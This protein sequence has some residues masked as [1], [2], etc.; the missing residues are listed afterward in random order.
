M[1]QKYKLAALTTA[2][3]LF[4]G[5]CNATGQEESSRESVPVSSGSAE[6]S[7]A[8]DSPAS[9][10]IPASSKEN[11]SSQ[12]AEKPA[13]EDSEPKE[14]F[15][16]APAGYEPFQEESSGLYQI[17]QPSPDIPY[18]E[19]GFRN[20]GEG[21][22]L[23]EYYNEKYPGM[24]G[25]DEYQMGNIV[26][27]DIASK[28]YTTAGD[29]WEAGYTATG[30]PVM[31]K[32]GYYYTSW[33]ED[34]DQARCI[35]KIDL[36]TGQRT[37][38]VI[39]ENDY[40]AGIGCWTIKMDETHFLLV[41]DEK[42]AIYDTDKDEIQT[43]PEDTFKNQP[44][45]QPDGKLYEITAPTKDKISGEWSLKSYDPALN[46]IE[47]YEHIT[48]IT[49]ISAGEPFQK[50]LSDGETMSEYPF[51]FN[52]DDQWYWVVWKENVP[53]RLLG[54]GS[55]SRSS[56][57]TS[58]DM[59]TIF[60]WKDNILYLMDI[61]TGEIRILDFGWREKYEGMRLWGDEE[62]NIILVLQE[63]REVQETYCF[64]PRSTI[65]KCAVPY[66]DYVKGLSV[67]T[68]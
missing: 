24:S 66:A 11:V 12:Q 42:I 54:L 21:K 4:L 55:L 51:S 34:A 5:G 19:I 31:M 56:T 58:R 29:K 57:W 18:G 47:E 20:F 23:F 67:Q 48:G 41:F 9:E 3:L 27:Y 44:V 49:Y 39:F 63:N 60:F 32:S 22:V 2:I 62:G 15:V 50:Y 8:S 16:E 30:V 43:L 53:V 40:S 13:P 52:G 46:K 61:K 10:S 35:H 37:T 25:T 17:I 28:Q 1:N 38:P 14:I 26:V 64:I 36:T 7:P 65:D 6:P 33:T 45:Y 68:E 59:G